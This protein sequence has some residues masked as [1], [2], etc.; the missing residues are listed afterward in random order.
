MGHRPFCT[1]L[2]FQAIDFSCKI[3]FGNIFLTFSPSFIKANKINK[4]ERENSYRVQVFY[5]YI[6]F[7]PLLCLFF[8]LLQ[9]RSREQKVRKTHNFKEK[10]G[11]KKK[12]K[13][14]YIEVFKPFM[15]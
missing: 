13:R 14:S 4:E 2:I 5:F 10:E 3:N 7:L 1:K 6:P 12:R 9:K 8:R 11:K 15:T